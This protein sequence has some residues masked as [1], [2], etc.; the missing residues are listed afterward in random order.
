M[1][2]R[3][4]V[5]IALAVLA[6]TA[7]GAG[8]LRPGPTP[9]ANVEKVPSRLVT[10]QMPVR[11]GESAVALPGSAVVRLSFTL[12]FEN[13]SRLD[14]ML[15]G[16]S[17]PSSPL[18]RAYLTPSQFRTEFSPTAAA[19]D[20]VESALDRVGAT[21]LSVAP[22]R[23]AIQADLTAS[24]VRSLLG[25]ELVSVTGPVGAALYTSVGTARLA[26]SLAGL[27]TGVGG[28]SDLGNARAALTARDGPPRPVGQFVVERGTSNQWDVG[29]DFAQALGATALWPGSNTTDATYPSDVAIATLLASSYNST[30]DHG[31]GVNLPP[32][33]P[34]VV[35]AY[36]NATLGPGW[37]TPTVTGVPVT[38]DSITPPAPGSLHGLNDTSSDE[39]ENSLD[40][41]M[42]GSLAPGAALYNFY[43]PGSL[44]SDFGLSTGDIA[45]DFALDLSDAL[46]Y[47][48]APDHLAVVSGS[49]GLAEQNDSLWDSGLEEAAALGVT[50]VCASGDQGDAPALLTDR[51][52]PWPTWPATAAFADT[53]VIS[54]GGTTVTLAGRRRR[55]PPL[56]RSTSRSTRA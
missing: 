27:V 51:G 53:G 54:V 10:D 45:D 25:V 9:T 26:D 33:D 15:G 12:A 18:Y 1:V 44:M 38:V 31:A 17:N 55:P 39:F 35:N 29:S 52:N 16:L 36:F 40:L 3:E 37:P 30:Y 8:A 11:P 23:L 4:A 28:L 47:D 24:S 56:S 48:Y 2:A 50:V 20:Q 34:A 32:F 6:L 42:A 49:F 21:D 19:V 7:M 5:A 14:G 41:E 22:G 43:F 13:A 46:A